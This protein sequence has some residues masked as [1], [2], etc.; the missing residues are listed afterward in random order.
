MLNDKNFNK[1]GILLSFKKKINVSYGRLRLD[2]QKSN[3]QINM[4]LKH[5][6]NIV[7]LLF[8][9]K[10]LYHSSEV[11][12]ICK[13]PRHALTFNTYLELDNGC[14]TRVLIFIQT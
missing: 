11:I 8:S 3:L 7:C 4:Y 6:G 9:F 1:F 5:R 10:C 13:I 14:H 2:D 12:K